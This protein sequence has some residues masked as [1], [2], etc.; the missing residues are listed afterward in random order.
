MP[1]DVIEF[2]WWLQT[3][4][5]VK[6]VSRAPLIAFAISWL[7]SAPDVFLIEIKLSDLK[8]ITVCLA[9]AVY[10]T[11]EMASDIRPAVCL[12]SNLNP[13]MGTLKPHSN[14]PLHRNMVIGTLADDGWYIWYSEE[15]TGRGHSPTRCFL[16]VPNVIAHPSTTRVPTSYYSMWH[17]N[18]LCTIKS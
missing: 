2:Q 18:C 8:Y 14:G 17:Y 9:N 7:T 12:F 6:R 3:A 15:G 1:R 13:L 5:A 10:T 16:A 11:T 4:V